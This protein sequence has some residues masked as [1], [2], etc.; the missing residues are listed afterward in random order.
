MI[1]HNN[2]HNYRCMDYWACFVD[3]SQSVG[4]CQIHHRALLFLP[5]THSLLLWNSLC[6]FCSKTIIMWLESWFYRLYLVCVTKSIE[7]LFLVWPKLLYISWKCWPNNYIGNVYLN[8]S[9]IAALIHLSLNAIKH[10]PYKMLI[11]S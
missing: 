2:N 11:S 8:I 9:T 6:I 10:I 7:F 3:I 1:N 4:P 5:T